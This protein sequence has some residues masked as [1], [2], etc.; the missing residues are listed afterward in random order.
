VKKLL[1][2]AIAAA[3]IVPVLAAAENSVKEPVSAATSIDED[4]SF[5][6]AME[7]G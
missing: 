1:T 4:A 2:L 3:L 7:K 5:K 6:I